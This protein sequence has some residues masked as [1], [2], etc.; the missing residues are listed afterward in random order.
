MTADDEIV[1]VVWDGAK[2]RDRECFSLVSGGSCSLAPHL[3][4][5]QGTGGVLPRSACTAAAKSLRH[6]YARG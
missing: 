2:D 5:A 4:A 1:V 3:V 6:D